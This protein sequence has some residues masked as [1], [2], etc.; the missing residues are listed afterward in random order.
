MLRKVL[1]NAG[2]ALIFL[3]EPFT[4]PLGL[5]L[6]GTAYLMGRFGR[7]QTPDYL[8]GF[9]KMYLDESR[10]IG[11]KKNVIQHKLRQ[12]LEDSGW[13]CQLK[14]DVPR[15]I[16]AGRLTVRFGKEMI[17]EFAEPAT[18]FQHSLKERWAGYVWPEV[19]LDINVTQPATHVIDFSRLSFCRLDNNCGGSLRPVEKAVYHSLN[20]GLSVNV[21]GE[22]FHGIYNNVSHVPE[23]PRL[24]STRTPP[25]ASHEAE[26]DKVIY[27]NMK[28]DLFGYVLSS[29]PVQEEKVVRHTMDRTRLLAQYEQTV[30][31]RAIAPKEISSALVA[32]RSRIS[33]RADYRINT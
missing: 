28:P 1:R 4:T 13:R 24:S 14:N 9:I 23:A 33:L 2:F 6:L 5:V 11:G 29:V 30:P 32:R 16:D 20:R 15:C 19:S 10:P 17:I 27:H 26:A 31:S 8:R 3:P 25:F 18:P 22:K 7:I 21:F 12:K